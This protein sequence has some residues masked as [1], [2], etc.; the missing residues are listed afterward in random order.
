MSL[1]PAA[2]GVRTSATVSLFEGADAVTT[3]L[4]SESPD[5]PL[6]LGRALPRAGVL[7]P[8]GMLLATLSVQSVRGLGGAGPAPAGV[9]VSSEYVLNDPDPARDHCFVAGQVVAGA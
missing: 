9:T 6:G 7:P 5:N 1:T 2:D 8:N 3:Q 4:A